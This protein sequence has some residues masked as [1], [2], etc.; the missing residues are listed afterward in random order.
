MKSKIRSLSILLFAGSLAACAT[1]EPEVKEV[2]VD[3]AGI[4]LVGERFDGSKTTFIEA[5]DVH[6]ATTTYVSL[7]NTGQYLAYLRRHR[8]GPGYQY[9]EQP[10]E[11]TIE[12][13]FDSRA[14]GKE[15]IDQPPE[16]IWAEKGRV[17]T[18]RGTANYQMFEID[19][20][21]C[22]GFIQGWGQPGA[23]NSLDSYLNFIDGYFCG[24][25]ISTGADVET[26]INSVKIQ[27]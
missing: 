5:K 18:G 7:Y 20:L 21:P 24:N 14:P 1:A 3:E 25:S 4:I 6:T 15:E 17:Q 16:L 22:V 12:A 13:I 27:R 19:D 2:A 23:D 9:R 8:A 11:K 26:L 10:V